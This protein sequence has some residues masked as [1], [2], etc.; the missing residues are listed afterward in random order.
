MVLQCSKPA[1]LFRILLSDIKTLLLVLAR[2]GDNAVGHVSFFFVD[3]EGLED[4]VNFRMP[5]TSIPHKSTTKRLLA[6][7]CSGLACD[8][9][10]CLFL[11][12]PFKIHLPS[13]PSHRPFCFMLKILI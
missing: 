2:V 4:P 11:S 6:S 7:T 10:H 8:D 9:Y 12:T 13:L 1:S 5:L 3:V